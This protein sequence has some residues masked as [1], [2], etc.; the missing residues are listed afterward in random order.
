MQ[1][2][3]SL[4]V[5]ISDIIPGNELGSFTESG[6]VKRVEEKYFHL[7][8]PLIISISKDEIILEYPEG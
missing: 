7:P 8:H 4:R 2:L 5:N 1:K 3:K 6:I